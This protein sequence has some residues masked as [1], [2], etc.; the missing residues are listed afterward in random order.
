MYYTTR[1]SLNSLLNEAFGYETTNMMRSDIKKEDGNYVVEIEMPGVKKEEISLSLEKGYLNVAVKQAKKQEGVE[2]VL[3]ER[4][5][6]EYS[7]NYYLG[8]GF[9]EEDIRASLSDGILRLVFPQV[10]KAEKKVISID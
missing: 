10:K 9:V 5:K 3:N 1:N 4:I 6:G 2:Y 7:R 8:D